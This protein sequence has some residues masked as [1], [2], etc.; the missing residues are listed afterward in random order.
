MSE[1]NRAPGIAVFAVAMLIVVLVG[2]WFS[3]Y[4]LG[5]SE[6]AIGTDFDN[7]KISALFFLPDV[8]LS[9]A[10]YW[11]GGVLF[12]GAPRRA[13]IIAS[14]IAS[15]GLVFAW[16]LVVPLMP[17]ALNI[18]GFAVYCLVLGALSR[19]V[20]SRVASSGAV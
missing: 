8:V 9:S 4:V 5:Q 19:I 13:G 12:R 16:P 17:N 15:G 2:T 1:T 20:V 14:A 6:G 10:G 18:V 11:L 7:L 3:V